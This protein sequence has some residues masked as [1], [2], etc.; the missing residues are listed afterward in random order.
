MEIEE[1][2]NERAASRFSIL[3]NSCLRRLGEEKTSICAP[4]TKGIRKRCLDSI[5]LL[6]LPSDVGD[7]FGHAGVLEVNGGGNH[8]LVDCQSREDSFNCAGRPK[9][10]PSGSLGGGDERLFLIIRSSHEFHDGFSFFSV[11]NRSRS[12]VSI[13]IIDITCLNPALLQSKVHR[14]ESSFPA[15]SANVVCVP[16]KATPSDLSVYLSATSLRMLVLLKHHNAGSLP[17]H[18]PCTL[19][20]EWP[21]CLFRLVVKLGDEGVHSVESCHGERLDRRL[22]STSNHNIGL[23]VFNELEG[24]SNAVR[25]GSAC[26]DSSDVWAL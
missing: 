25:A 8:S 18:K 11:S 13:D 5:N 3:V 7:A 15:R 24:V 14:S 23:S 17:H 21:R 12:P 26:C 22:C 16:R 4:E 9:H 2:G 1:A 20:I 19:L 6:R 10:V